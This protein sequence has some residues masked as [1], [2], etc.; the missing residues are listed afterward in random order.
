MQGHCLPPS[1]LSLACSWSC[2]SSRK[3]GMRALDAQVGTHRPCRAPEPSTT[4]LEAGNGSRWEHLEV[5]AEELPESMNQ[6]EQGG[7][8]RDSQE[9]P[10]PGYQP[11]HSPGSDPDLKP[12]SLLQHPPLLPQPQTVTLSSHKAPVLCK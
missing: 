2:G 3:E 8:R 5:G 11:R 4:R 10:L 12:S 6:Q 1:P 7:S 9:P